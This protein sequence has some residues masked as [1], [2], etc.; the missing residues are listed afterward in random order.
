MATKWHVNEETGAMGECT[1]QPGN[2]PVGGGEDAHFTNQAEAKVASEKMLEAKH[3][4]LNGIKRKVRNSNVKT[5]A[6]VDASN[7][8]FNGEVMNKR[9]AEF[10]ARM[11][12][13]TSDVV[14]LRA[15]LGDLAADQGKGDPV[16]AEESLQ[17]A[18]SYASKRNNTHLM[19]K[20]SKAKALP[21]SVII[22]STGDKIY[23]DDL[24]DMDRAYKHIED[25]R[26]AIKASMLALKDAPVGK[27][28]EKT[29]AG[30]FT[31]TVSDDGINE[32]ELAKLSAEKREQISTPYRNLS[33]DLARDNLT[34][35][36]FKQVV[37]ETQALDYVNGRPRDVGLKEVP[38]K[39]AFV[40]ANDAEKMQDGVKSIATMYGSSK[41]QFGL[42]T[43]EVKAKRDSMATSIKEAAALNSRTENTYVPGRSRYNGLVVSGRQMIDTEAARSILSPEKVEAI[44]NISHRPNAKK[45]E[46]VLTKEE[47]GKIFNK[48]Q[49][50]IRVTEAK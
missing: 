41:K 19:E 45:A 29:D 9:E 15:K 32:N 26:D 37:K 22:T 50:G 14:T 46:T 8:T 3:S 5:R 10:R 16:R 7:D 24:S 34:D 35:A 42:S 13:M 11:A 36:E 6:S 43:K 40:G 17:N 49:V 4:P 21:T 25:G 1:A 2:C 30:T 39:T 28:T 33:I 23:S 47:F 18:I 38:V 12:N 31:V 44:T 48:R 27:Y 20:L